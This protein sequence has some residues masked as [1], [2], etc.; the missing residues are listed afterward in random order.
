MQQKSKE[1]IG[2]IVNGLT[3]VVY[4]ALLSVLEIPPALDILQY[5]GWILL[6][7]GIALVILAFAALLGKHTKAVI[8]RGILSVVRHP[9]YLGAMFIFLAMVFFLPHW[10]MAILSLVSIIY[11]YWFMVVEETRNIE[12]FGDDYES[13]MQLV[14]RVNLLAGFIKLLLRRRKVK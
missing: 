9:M 13:Y 12:K 14:P 4:F 6:A 1:V 3:I 2:Y 5:V 7:V 8:D 11:I 10:I